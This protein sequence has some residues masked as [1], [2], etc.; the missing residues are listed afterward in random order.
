MAAVKAW[1]AYNPTTMKPGAGRMAAIASRDELSRAHAARFP[2][3][4]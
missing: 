2:E 4:K 3:S 1:L